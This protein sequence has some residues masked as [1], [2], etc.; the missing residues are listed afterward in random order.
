MTLKFVLKCI[1]REK[2][3]VHN[4]EVI[5]AAAVTFSIKICFVF[6]L[7]T[8]YIYILYIYI[9]ILYIYIYIYIYICDK[10]SFSFFEFCCI[11]ESMVGNGK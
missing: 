4:N 9:Y 3:L 2:L 11:G 10:F 5:K 1:I 8:L 7:N 6:S